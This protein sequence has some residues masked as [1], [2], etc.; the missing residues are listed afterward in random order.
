[1]VANNP[2]NPRNTCFAQCLDPAGN[3][4][5]GT[6][7]GLNCFNPRTGHFTLYPAPDPA[8]PAVFAVAADKAGRAWA[9]CAKG[10]FYF[11]SRTESYVRVAPSLPADSMTVVFAICPGRDGELWVAAKQGLYRVSPGGVTKLFRPPQAFALEERVLSKPLWQDASGTIWAALSDQAGLQRF[12]PATRQWTVYQARPASPGALS[13]NQ[14]FALYRDRSG[15]LW[16]GGDNGLDALMPQSQVFRTV[17]FQADAY[18][19]RLPQNNIRALCQDRA[20]T[21]WVSNGIGQ[22]ARCEPGGGP[23]VLYASPRNTL[24]KERINAILE[25]QAGQLW[26]GSDQALL[27]LNRHTQQLTRYPCTTG[28]RTIRQAPDGTLWLGGARGVAAFAP[29]TARFRYYPADPQAPNGLRSAG[30]VAVLPTRAG[31]WIATNDVGLVRLDPVTGRFTYCSP[32]SAPVAQ[33][34]NDKDIRALFEDGAGILWVGTNQGGLNW[35]NPQTDGFGAFTTRDGLPSNHIAGILADAVG[36]LWLATNQG[37]CRFT[38]RAKMCR[39]YDQRDGLQD[40]VFSEACAQGPTGELLFGGPNGFN[41]FSPGKIRDN[42]QVPP[43][44]ITGLQV[45]NKPWLE[46]PRRLSL[47]HQENLLSFSFLALNFIRPEKISTPT[48]W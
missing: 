41:L 20:G 25:D 47:P 31:M 17:Q 10:L 9:G 28:V 22:L 46:V 43:V 32:A 48:S 18:A 4:W 5:L 8:H 26:L 27:R 16:V 35:R 24:T 21:V 37:L 39:T 14:I 34:P 6:A 12:D 15:I 3:F 1:M 13:S 29:A 2:I 30:I 44:Y 40:N 36:N 7:G 38:P 11:N 19:T 42:Q 45:L 23:L 33:G